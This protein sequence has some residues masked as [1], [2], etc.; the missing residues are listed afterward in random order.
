LVSSSPRKSKKKEMCEKRKK[1]WDCP[2]DVEM[3]L[4]NSQA[5]MMPE[6][7]SDRRRSLSHTS[8]SRSLRFIFSGA[9]RCNPSISLRRVNIGHH[10]FFAQT[11]LV[12]LHLFEVCAD[13]NYLFILTISLG[14]YQLIGFYQFLGFYQILFI[15][16]LMIYL[17]Q[18]F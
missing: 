15:F 13:F 1:G 9:Q 6:W 12:F 7:L 8:L 3:M 17:P 5:M 14:F 16:Y 4:S 11:Q 18:A 10:T 2:I